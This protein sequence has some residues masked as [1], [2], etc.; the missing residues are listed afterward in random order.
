LRSRVKGIRFLKHHA[1]TG[2]TC[3][4]FQALIDLSDKRIVDDEIIAILT[5]AF[6]EHDARVKL[7]ALTGLCE[8]ECFPLDRDQVKALVEKCESVIDQEM[9][10]QAFTY[11]LHAFPAE[12]KERL[13]A[14]AKS[15]N[16]SIRMNTCH[17]IMWLKMY[18]LT[19]LLEEL[20]KDSDWHVSI[21]AYNALEMLWPDK[22]WRT[23]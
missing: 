5:A 22:I 17:E 19:T 23:Q 10:R 18:E 6:H 2:D 21:S 16:S 4:R 7:G 3:I 13:I 15:P 8:I 20:T 1:Q 9:G 14:G 11:L 12:A